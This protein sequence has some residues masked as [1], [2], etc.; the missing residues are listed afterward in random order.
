VAAK[1]GLIIEA[2]NSQA[3]L[4]TISAAATAAGALLALGV[5]AM[6][7]GLIRTE[8]AGDQR[9][10]TAAGA[11]SSTRRTLTAATA[12]VLALLG[13]L[14]GSADAYLALA[15]GHRSD[16]SILGRVPVPYLA[17][18]VLGV[19]VVAALAGWV[20]AGRQPTSIARPVLE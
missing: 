9:T 18:T 10:L 6:T 13:A 1:A 17:L 19:P 5:L 20:L 14:L 4:A 11:T 16:L 2:R 7:V 8:A 12:G 3:S 15:A